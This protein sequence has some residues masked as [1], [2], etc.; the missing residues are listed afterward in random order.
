[1]PRRSERQKEQKETHE[2]RQRTVRLRRRTEQKQEEQK[3]KQKPT[4]QRRKRI[5]LPQP[6]LDASRAE[7]ISVPDE[8]EDVC[9]LEIPDLAELPPDLGEGEHKERGAILN[10]GGLGEDEGEGERGERKIRR[11]LV[12]SVLFE[13]WD[14]K[15]RQGWTLRRA[16]QWLTDHNFNVRYK[17]RGHLTVGKYYRFKQNV[18]FRQKQR[19]PNYRY[20]YPDPT[21]H[22]VKLLVF[23][24][25]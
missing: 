16:R 5:S 10:L 19:L 14:R 7:E 22:S 13:K 11:S 1:M 23:F 9:N 15:T 2:Q 21:D 6:R 12:S 20:A 25:R 3:Q 17:Q 18:V 24:Y 4:A 8:S